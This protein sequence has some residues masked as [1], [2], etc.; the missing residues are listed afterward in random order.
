[1]KI[2]T[3][4]LTE[5]FSMGTEYSSNMDS[6]TNKS[7]NPNESEHS[8][9]GKLIALNKL[10]ITI[11]S[12]I[13]SSNLYAIDSTLFK[14]ILNNTTNFMNQLSRYCIRC[15]N[16]LDVRNYTDQEKL[17]NEMK[18]DLEHFNSEVEAITKDTKSLL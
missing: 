6:G 15:K 18:C 2:P 11:C 14:E 3:N 1:M 5:P 10:L 12:S 8:I 9:G 17:I 7:Q 16:E 13:E 4:R